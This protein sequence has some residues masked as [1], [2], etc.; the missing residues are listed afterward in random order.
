MKVLKNKTYN[1]LILKIRKLESDLKKQIEKANNIQKDFNDEIEKYATKLVDEEMRNIKIQANLDDQTDFITSLNKRVQKAE[2]EAEKY[3]NK[4]HEQRED[5]R[6]L[7]DER[8]ELESKLSRK[9]LGVKGKKKNN[10]AF[11]YD[12][13]TEIH[14]KA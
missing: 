6:L 2:A 5:N 1:D 9:G 14:K 11:P 7:A 13:N 4:F 8:D 10:G 12:Y 3:F